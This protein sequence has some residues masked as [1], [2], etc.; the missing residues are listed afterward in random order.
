MVAP[1]LFFEDVFGVRR[2]LI[3]VTTC[4]LGFNFEGVKIDLE[5]VELTLFGRLKGE[6]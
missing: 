1:T 5:L 2:C 6:F 4:M 3:Y